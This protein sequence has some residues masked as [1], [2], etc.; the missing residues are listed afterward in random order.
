MG[1]IAC[2]RGLGKAKQCLTLTLVINVTHLLCS[3]LFINMLEMGVAGSGWSFIVARVVGAVAAIA[4]MLASTKEMQFTYRDLLRVRAAFLKKI[5][6]LALPFA[7]EQMLF[8]AGQLLTSTYISKLPGDS[9]AAN[10]IA[11]SIFNLLFMTAFALQNLIMTV[12]GQCIGAKHFDL[13]RHYVKKFIRF[14]RVA[15]LI[16]ALLVAP[17]LPLLMMLYQP[18]ATV[19]PMVYVMLGIGA[20]A[21]VALWCDG[22]LIPACLRAAGD[23][24]FT[25]VI[26]L[27]SMWLS[28]VAVGYLLTMVLGVGVYGVWLSYFVDYGFRAVVFHLRFKGHKWEQI[29]L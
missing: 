26:C 22:Y 19:E 4:L 3:F 27:I 5:V 8:Q 20:V 12:C 18:S 11:L 6:V 9:I 15:I 16:N 17:L 7:I 13:A 24:T 10:S 14:Y 2:F 21:N 23:A 29:K 1:V 28:K 25:T